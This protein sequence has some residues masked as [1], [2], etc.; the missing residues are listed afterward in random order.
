MKIP[1][2]THLQFAVLLALK[3]GLPKRGSAIREW[4]AEL[5]QAHVLTSF[6]ALMNR[7][8]DLVE[9]EPRMSMIGKRAVTES[10]YTI[11]KKGLEKMELARKFYERES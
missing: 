6:Y 2:L 4:L 5:D 1:E 8:S 11:T 9:K 3:D 10:W 7:M